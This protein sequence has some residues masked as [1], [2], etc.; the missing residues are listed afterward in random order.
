MKY[1]RAVAF[2][3]LT[4]LVYLGVPLLG[5]GLTDLQ[6]FLAATPRLLS[7]GLVIAFGLAAGVKAIDAPQ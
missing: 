4:V 2:M 5:W 7:A 6:G 1:L 3:L